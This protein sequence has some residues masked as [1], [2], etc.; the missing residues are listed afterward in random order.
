MFK[1]FAIFPIDDHTAIHTVTSIRHHSCSRLTLHVLHIRTRT[2]NIGV[3]RVTYSN[4]SY[5]SIYEHI[6]HQLAEYV[7]SCSMLFCQVVMY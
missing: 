2:V 5:P 6:L 3:I 1:Y 7:D 4:C